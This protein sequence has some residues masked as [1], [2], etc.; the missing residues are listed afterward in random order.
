MKA[1]LLPI[2]AKNLERCTDLWR[3][4]LERVPSQTVK[5][6]RLTCKTTE[7]CGRYYTEL[8][9]VYDLRYIFISRARF[10]KALK[11]LEHKNGAWRKEILRLLR[12]DYIDAIKS[13]YKKGI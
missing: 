3:R 8:D 12:Q 7:A 4:R 10:N 1:K 5:F 13:M 11:I 6:T 9:L 2:D